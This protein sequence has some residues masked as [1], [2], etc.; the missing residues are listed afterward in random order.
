ML[1]NKEKAE[2]RGKKKMFSEVI[3]IVTDSLQI[4]KST[5]PPTY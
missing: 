3:V 5:S 4:Y 2:Q 1:Q